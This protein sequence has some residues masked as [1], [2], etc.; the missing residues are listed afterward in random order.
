V[1]LYKRSL[2][3]LVSLVV[4]LPACGVSRLAKGEIQ[5]PKVTFQGLA[6][7]NPTSKGWP[8]SVTLLLTN[9]NDQALDLKGYDCE[10]WLEG[11]SVAQ[12]ASD[13]PVN[14]PSHGQT[15][16]RVPIFVKLS[17]VMELLPKLLLPA[18]PPVYY[19]VAGSF[20]LGAVLGG[21]VPVPFRFQGQVTP[22]QGLDLLR[23][24]LRQ[25]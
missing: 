21:L 3:L 15:V 14:L 1:R 24:Y 12:A 19:Q 16:A 25:K 13:A 10:L 22:K 2:A 17:A 20:R 9:P 5:P 11:K 4:L 18:P 7:G 6:L 8:V 23:P